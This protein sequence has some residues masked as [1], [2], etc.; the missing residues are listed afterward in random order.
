MPGQL[1]LTPGPGRTPYLV[2]L[3]RQTAFELRLTLRRTDTLVVMTL[4]PLLALVGVGL[5][6]VVRLPT[7]DRMGFIVPG[8]LA[9]A[10]MS[11]AFVGL[12]AAT[13]RERA[14]GV[15]KRLVASALPTWGLLAA[16][17]A[18]AVA[19]IELQVVLLAGTG[20]LLGWRPHL[21]G[22]VGAL[23]LTALATVA[24][25]ALGLLVAGT[26]R[27]DTASAVVTLLHLV[28]IAFGNVVFP[29]PEGVV[30]GVQLLPVTA[31][32]EGLRSTLSEGVGVPAGYWSLLGLWTV[33]ASMAVVLR[34][35]WK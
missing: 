18:S 9:L 12:S 15:L 6:D 33:T 8:A 24:F 2:V 27:A 13:G 7:D 21:S 16:K 19:V 28:L 1:D 32:A 26:M 20:L 30:Q 25:A 35:R 29:L 17:I 14:D 10:V 23:G 22:V 31:L 4:P 34:F 5:T 3:A 11:T